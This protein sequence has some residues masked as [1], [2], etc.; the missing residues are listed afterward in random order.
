M[1]WSKAVLLAFVGVLVLAG[2]AM[3]QPTGCVPVVPGIQDGTFEAG[4]PWPAWTVQTSTNFGSPV[5][6][7]ALCGTGARSAPPFAGSNWA[8]FGGIDAAEASTL[9]QTVTIPPGMFLFL[10]FQMRIGAVATPFTDTLV[11]RVD[12]IPVAT[13][14][15]PGTAEPDYSERYVNVTAFANGSPHAVS[16]AYDHPAGGTLSSFTVD[17]V[18][19]LTC[20][21]PVEVLDFKI[22]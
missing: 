20:T 1:S 11:V 12:A 18:E 4:M 13:F 14:A 15:E 8:W 16:F 5:C 19:L 10:R 22:E 2:G 9:G 3:A 7:L 6:D 17:D 21:T